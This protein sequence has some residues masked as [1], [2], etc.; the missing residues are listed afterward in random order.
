MGTKADGVHTITAR[1]YQVQQKVTTLG[2][3]AG[4]RIVQV[5]TTIHAGPHVVIYG[6]RAADDPPAQWKN[7]LVEVGSNRYVEIYGLQ[8]DWVRSHIGSAGIYG[9]GPNSILGTY[10]PGDGNGGGCSEGYWW[11]D[12][13]GAHPV[14]FS[15]LEDAIGRAIPKEGTYTHSCSALRATEGRFDSWVQRTDAK[16]HACGGLG[17]VH[18]GYRIQKGV[19]IP[20]SVHFEAENEQSK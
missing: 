16:C 13:A 15:A 2:T 19:A 8:I 1:D 9:A 10:D 20:V 17:T 18:A 14:D 5:L 12:A 6:Q 11:F 3:I 4:H 7:L